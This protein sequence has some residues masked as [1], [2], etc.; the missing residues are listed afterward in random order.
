MFPDPIPLL[1]I[2]LTVCTYTEW[3][4]YLYVFQLQSLANRWDYLRTMPI[5][6]N[7]NNFAFAS[8]AQKHYTVT[9]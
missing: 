4:I 5:T 1:G 6:V 9:P 7:Y 8:N 2:S 3:A